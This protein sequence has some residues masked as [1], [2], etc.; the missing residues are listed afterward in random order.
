MFKDIKARC[1]LNCIWPKWQG[2]YIGHYKR[3]VIGWLPRIVE[4][5]IHSNEEAFTQI[6]Q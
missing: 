2:R 6:L 4:M 5:S 1:R 3:F